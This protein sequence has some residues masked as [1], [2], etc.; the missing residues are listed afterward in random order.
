MPKVHNKLV[1]DKIPQMLAAKGLKSTMN[2]D[3]N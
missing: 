1:R 2:T 3:V